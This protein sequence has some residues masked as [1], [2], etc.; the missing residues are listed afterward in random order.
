[1]E[2]NPFIPANE[3]LPLKC[4]A[5]Q[6]DLVTDETLEVLYGGSAGGGKTA[7][8][9]IAALQYVDQPGYHAL[10]LR[11]TFKQ[12][13]KADSI[14]SLCTNWI[15]S[16]ARYTSDSHTFRFP[17]GATLEFG[18]CEHEKNKT[19]YDGPAYH[20]VGID[21][22][23]HFTETMYSYIAFGRQR[24]LLDS[25]IPLRIRLSAMPGGEG[26]TWVKKR[27]VSAKTTAMKRFLP[28]RLDD[29]PFLDK[30]EYR[31][32]LHRM[33]E[34]D[35]ITA[36][37]MEEGDWDAIIGSRFKPEWFKKYHRVRHAGGWWIDCDGL[38]I[39]IDICPRF[40]TIDTA[41][42]AKEKTKPDPDYTVASS[43]AQYNNLLIWLGCRRDR[44]ESPDVP[45]FVGAEYQRLRIGVAY[46]EETGAMKP[47][48]Y[49]KRHR[50]GNGTYMNVVPYSKGSA[51]KLLFNTPFIN[52]MAAGRVWMPEDDPHFP[53]GDVEGELLLFTGNP[54][55]DS[56]DDIVDTGGAAAKVVDR[57]LSDSAQYG[58]DY[59]VECFGLYKGSP[60][61]NQ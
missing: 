58:D 22:A 18:H 11:R 27:F 23:T 16:K 15:G 37:R 29:N 34:V 47:S 55:Q 35:P 3:R 61:Y 5:K 41:S 52:M 25:T 31:K 44:M 56:H 12:L 19:D 13:S 50:L 51:D 14:L 20:F 28:A 43:W 9:L 33:G 39:N 24:R 49:L 53:L 45:P 6:L 21:E 59:G 1:M 8:I 40:M 32:S 57:V 30:D 36:K 48:Q 7:A 60:E 17:S 42:T 46:V 2:E 10:I 26:H 54:K 4:S 38:R